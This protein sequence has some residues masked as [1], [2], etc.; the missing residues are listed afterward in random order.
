VGEHGVA[1]IHVGRIAAEKNLDLLVRA[2]RHLQSVRP[3]ARLVWVGDGPERAG[4]QQAHPDF[5]FS[6][7]QRGQALAR[8]FASGDLFVF[9]SHSETFGNVTLEAMASG[10]PTVAFDYGAAH[11]HLRDELH[12][13]AIAA[14]D[15]AGF[16]RAVV[17]LGTDD[18]LRRAMGSA[19][20][21]ATLGLRPEQVA[22]DFDEL[23][24]SLARRR[25]AATAAPEQA[26]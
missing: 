1:A 4:L 7:I 10:V 21:L 8:H 11:E 6:G 23:L 12:G 3:E 13:A 15:D 19:A 2:F 22:A 5:I 24:Q 9:P 17:R 20:R 18:R 25:A 14:G 26:A 16:I